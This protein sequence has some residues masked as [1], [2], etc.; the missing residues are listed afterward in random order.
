MEL[1]ELVIE[2][3]L[4]SI[5][6]LVFIVILWDHII[7]D[8]R[9]TKRVQSYYEDVENFIFSILEKSYFEVYKLSPDLSTSEKERSEK[10]YSSFSQKSIYYKN[11]LLGEMIKYYRYLGFTKLEGSSTPLPPIG[12]KTSD[13]RVMNKEG[14]SF[15][16]R[17]NF[18]SIYNYDYSEIDGKVITDTDLEFVREFLKSIREFRKNKY[19]K[20]LVRP[21]LKSVKNFNNLNGFTNPNARFMNPND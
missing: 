7:D 4:G 21:K 14:Y 5:S 1:F 18:I 10:S 3:M 8:R 17:K 19:S 9:L 13:V 20:F 6:A 16:F 12:K 11:I 15:S 2:I